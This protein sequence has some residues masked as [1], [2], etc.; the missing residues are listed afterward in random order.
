MVISHQNGIIRY[1]YKNSQIDSHRIKYRNFMSTICPDTHNCSIRSFIW[2][3]PF[4]STPYIPFPSPEQGLRSQNEPNLKKKSGVHFSQKTRALFLRGTKFPKDI[5][6]KKFRDFW[7]GGN[8]ISIY[9]KVKT[10]P[11]TYK[12]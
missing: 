1:K 10:K 3:C 5:S 9:I 12:I 7:V 4:I 2:G 8:Y 11:P 6:V